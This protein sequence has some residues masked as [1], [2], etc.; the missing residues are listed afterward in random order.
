M[1][2]E[3]AAVREETDS[4]DTR[5]SDAEFFAFA[6]DVIVA[7]R[8]RQAACHVQHGTTSTLL[9]CIAVAYEANKLAI[10]FGMD[11]ARRRETVR[12][13]LLHDYYLYDW[14]DGED[15][16]RMHGFRH[17]RFAAENARADY[18]DLTQDEENAIR[19][20]MFPLT[21]VP[22]SSSVGWVVTLADKK[23]AAYET[24]V[25]N[26]EAYPELRAKCARYLPDIPVDLLAKELPDTDQ[27][28]R[29]ATGNPR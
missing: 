6:H 12:A 24:R 17:A 21:P 28:L 7:G 16:H 3:S 13:A 25:R 22:P 29:P 27:S 1:D 4:Q 10:R 26:R 5:G 20:H 18:P 19:R 11:D 9:H 23:C 14:H 8:M 2:G 15:W